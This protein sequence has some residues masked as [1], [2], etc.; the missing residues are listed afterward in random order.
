L[1]VVS[2][3][4]NVPH[5]W[6]LGSI[7][8]RWESISVNTQIPKVEFLLAIKLILGSTF[9]S[10]NGLFYKQI[11]G[12]PMGS[13]L[14]PIISDLVLQDLE[15]LALTRLP[16]RLPFYFR[17]VDDILLAA[18]MD[19]FDTILEIFNSFHERLQFTLEISNSDR[20]NFLDVTIII[21]G[22][23]LAFDCFIISIFIAEEDRV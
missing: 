9:F 18:P 1:D 22:H 13:P 2:L 20:I 4:T 11:F 15:Q 6:V 10:F 23:R 14:S 19:C 12:M 21:D 16:I 8:K 7:E 5:E 17:Y 3:F